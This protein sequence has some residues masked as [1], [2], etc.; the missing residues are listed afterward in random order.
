MPIREHFLRQHGRRGS[1]EPQ[2]F[3]TDFEVYDAE[4]RQPSS[5]RQA[6]RK[7]QQL[8]GQVKRALNLAMTGEL[9]DLYVEEVE[10]APDCGRLLV[11]VLV[12][13]KMPVAE[14]MAALRREGPRLRAEVASAITRKR[15]PDL[16]FVP[17]CV[18]G[19]DDE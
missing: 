10:A 17:V 14:V 12:P 5:Y 8:C 7:T 2:C 1:R 9:S 16:C 18:D 3:D 19:D 15:V 13:E 6:E 4:S 11:H